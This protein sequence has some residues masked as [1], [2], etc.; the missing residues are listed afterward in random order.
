M[1]EDTNTTKSEITSEILRI[2]LGNFPTIK[3]L[4]AEH[5]RAFNKFNELYDRGDDECYRFNGRM[6]SIRALIASTSATSLSELQAKMRI[7]QVA[8]E[9]DPKFECDAAGSA[10]DLAKSIA[11][12]MLLLEEGKLDMEIKM[13]ETTEVVIKARVSEFGGDWLVIHPSND[14]SKSIKIPARD[15]LA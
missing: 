5:D 11:A 2:S 13:D 3:S 1:T 12:D 14:L 9:L 6:W 7:L 8:V 15:L 4:A 10:R